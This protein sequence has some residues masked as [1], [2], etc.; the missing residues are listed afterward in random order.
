MPADA[1]SDNGVVF[2]HR[3]QIAA[4]GDML[5]REQILI[6]AVRIDRTSGGDLI[7]P[8]EVADKLL[9]LFQ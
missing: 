1:G 2:R 5:I 9:N 4:R 8:D 6:P 7:L 3:I